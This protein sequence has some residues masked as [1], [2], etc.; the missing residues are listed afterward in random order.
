MMF[1][2]L[3]ELGH[4]RVLTHPSKLLLVF[5]AR[6]QGLITLEQVTKGFNLKRTMAFTWVYYQ[7]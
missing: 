5:G 4:R 3:L 7:V 6:F 1:Q 2:A